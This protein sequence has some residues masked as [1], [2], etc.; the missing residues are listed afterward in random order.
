LAKKEKIKMLRRKKAQNETKTNG[1]NCGCLTQEQRKKLIA[2]MA[3]YLAEKRNFN[4]GDPIQDWLTAEK[5]V[6]QKLNLR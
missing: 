6:D 1:K 4:H 2:E 5:M 3:Y